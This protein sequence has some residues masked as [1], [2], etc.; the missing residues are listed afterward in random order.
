MRAVK[1][2]HLFLP[3]LG[4]ASIAFAA[5]PTDSDGIWPRCGRHALF[6]PHP[7]HPRQCEPAQG[8]LDLA[9]NPKPMPGQ[10]PRRRSGRC[11]WA[12]ARP[13]LDRLADRD[14]WRALSAD[15]LR[16]RRGDQ[17][18]YR[19]TDLGLCPAHGD[20]PPFRGV[21][22]WPGDGRRTPR[23]IFGTI[24]GRLIALDAKTGEIIRG[25]GQNGSVNLKTPRDHERLSQCRIRPHRAGRDPSQSDHSGQPRAGT[26]AARPGGAVAPSTIVSGKLA[27]T[28]SGIAQPGDKNH[29]TWEDEGWKRR[30]GVNVWNLITV[31]G[32][33]RHRLSVLGAPS[34]DRNG[35]DRKGANLT[36]PAWWR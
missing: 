22:Y 34:I 4:L 30:S 27:W 5:A 3:A 1:L 18:R 8:C 20:Q 12:R 10:P 31:D 17:R 35:Q 16:P 14:R 28:F 21:S 6:A 25:F 15:A 24:G 13:H 11:R 33:R 36:A 32:R 2:K 26:A 9:L 7:N 23:I 29:A 19:Q